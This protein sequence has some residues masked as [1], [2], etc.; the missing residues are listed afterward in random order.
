MS[1]EGN[2]GKLRE[3]FVTV[4]LVKITDG[5]DYWWA[6]W[7]FGITKELG[8]IPLSISR[9][10]R[11]IELENN[12]GITRYL[13]TIALLC[14]LLEMINRR[15]DRHWTLDSGQWT[16]LAADE[17]EILFSLAFF[18]QGKWLG[19]Q[20]LIKIQQNSSK[21]NISRL[22]LSIFNSAPK[23]PLTLLPIHLRTFLDKLSYL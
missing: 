6:G 2:R 3:G 7:Q 22:I 19:Q 21:I 4:L 13:T 23:T 8:C 17:W 14:I 16:G 20:Q 1:N 18:L 15:T 9:S 11:F 5:L 12:A 10:L